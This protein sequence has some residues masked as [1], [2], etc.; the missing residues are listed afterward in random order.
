[1]TQQHIQLSVCCSLKTCW[2]KRSQRNPKIPLETSELLEKRFLKFGIWFP[3]DMW[4]ASER[5]ATP[6]G[7]AFQQR[8]ADQ[9]S[10]Q[11]GCCSNHR[12]SNRRD[13]FQATSLDHDEVERI[14]DACI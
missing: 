3:H 13:G 1:M 8:N 10:Q 7:E 9:G 11:Q 2:L 5:S 6:Y 12:G 14:L 4:G